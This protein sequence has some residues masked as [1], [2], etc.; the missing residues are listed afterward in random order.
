MFDIVQ[1]AMW[2]KGDHLRYISLCSERIERLCVSNE[3]V[4]EMR[5]KCENIW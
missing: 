4:G 5:N 3:S 1:Y 2:K